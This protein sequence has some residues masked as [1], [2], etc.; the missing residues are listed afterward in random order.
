MTKTFWKVTAIIF[1][2]LF[3]AETSLIIYGTYLLKKDNENTLSCYY[4]VCKD[5]LDADYDTNTQLCN[6]YDND[7]LGNLIITKQELIR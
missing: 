3:V 4:D 2:I 1:I 7:V 5:S 6:C